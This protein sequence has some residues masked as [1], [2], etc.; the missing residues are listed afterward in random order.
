MYN[1]RFKMFCKAQPHTHL[2][3]YGH[4]PLTMSDAYLSQRRAVQILI[5]I[6]DKSQSK[7]CDFTNHTFADKYISG[8]QITVKNLMVAKHK[9]TLTTI[10]LLPSPQM[11]LSPPP[12][13]G[14]AQKLQISVCSSGSETL[15]LFKGWDK[16]AYWDALFKGQ[17]RTMRPSS[18]NV[19]E[20]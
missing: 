8:S 17:T 11:T 18:G 7:V 20:K 2:Y 4:C 9:T 5:F 3:G 10:I 1:F 15:N 19:K 12:G 6:P 13:G 14:Y 16:Q